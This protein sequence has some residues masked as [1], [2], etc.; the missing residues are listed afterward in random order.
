MVNISNQ[1]EFLSLHKQLIK[2]LHYKL[3][4]IHSMNV[5]FDIQLMS[6]VNENNYLMYAIEVPQQVAFAWDEND[7][8]T[9]TQTMYMFEYFDGVREL[10]KYDEEEKIF[11]VLDGGTW[12]EDLIP[13][14]H[15]EYEN[16]IALR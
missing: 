12:N 1:L 14:H 8:I 2:E 4:Q 9:L 16:Q 5:F 10:C 3:K 6:R 13:N 7:D 11:I 15:N